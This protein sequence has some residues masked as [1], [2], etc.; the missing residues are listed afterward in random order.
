[1]PCCKRAPDLGR[2][3]AMRVAS[4]VESALWAQFLILTQ[5]P[6]APAV[7]VPHAG[8]DVVVLTGML[9]DLQECLS[10]EA[11]GRAGA[12]RDR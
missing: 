6:T 8:L 1:M 2:R 10:F 5:R 7:R 12:A 4:V 3:S 9:A 11:S